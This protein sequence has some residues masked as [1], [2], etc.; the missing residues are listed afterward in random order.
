MVAVFLTRTLVRGHFMNFLVALT[1]VGTVLWIITGGARWWILMSAAVAF[2]G[3]FYFGFKIYVH[4]IILPFSLAALIPFVSI[5]QGAPVVAWRRLPRSA[6]VLF[7]LFAGNWLISAWLVRT[8]GGGG[9]GS[10]SRAYMNGFW[11]LIFLLPFQWYGATRRIR[12]VLALIYV[13]CLLRL[14]I[15]SIAVRS[16]S[17]LYVP[18]LNFVF[19]GVQ[20]GLAD[21]RI[22]GLQLL[23]LSVGYA[24]LTRSLLVRLLYAGIIG[25]AVWLILLSGGRV[26][27]GMLCVIPLIW[28][29]LLRKARWLVIATL[30]LGLIVGIFNYKPALIYRFPTQTQRALSILVRESSTSALDWHSYVRLS[31]EWHRRLGELGWQRWTEN[32]W[33]FLCG[34][35]VKPF[36][37]AFVSRLSTMEGRAQIAADLGAYEA[38]LWSVLGTMGLTGAIAYVL[39]FRGLLRG[40]LRALRRNGICDHVHIVYFLA[41]TEIAIWFPFCW[42]AGSYPSFELLLAS[43]AWAACEDSRYEHREAAARNDSGDAGRPPR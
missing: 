3:F 40:P 23:L 31:N 37:M 6:Y 28:G 20:T 39:L 9:L 41:V 22:S 29:V 42:I 14:L 43:I 34:N 13:A 30:G 35:R 11:P 24:S 15:V 8:H 25:V 4:E 16:E 27:V 5:R 17:I 10:L 26:S 32:L 1:G 21:F 33:T 7:T 38:G 2:S 18:Y 12:L 36:D 19:A